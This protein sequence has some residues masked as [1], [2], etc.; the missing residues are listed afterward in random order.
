MNI[1]INDIYN[2]ITLE[3]IARHVSKSIPDIVTIRHEKDDYD[4]LSSSLAAFKFDDF[5]KMLKEEY[6]EVTIYITEL[7][8]SCSMEIRLDNGNFLYYDIYNLT[9]DNITTLK[10]ITSK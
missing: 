6:Q 9:H 2:G 7:D 10:E 4:V 1:S 5:I 3:Y 8:E